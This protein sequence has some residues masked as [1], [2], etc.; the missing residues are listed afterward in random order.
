MKISANLDESLSSLQPALEFRKQRS[1]P[2]EENTVGTVTDAQPYDRSCG[3]E[4]CVVK[5]A[6]RIGD[7]RADVFRLEIGEVSEYLLLCR[8][9]G[10]HVQNVLD[11][12]PHPADAWPPAALIRI[13]GDALKLVHK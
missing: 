9:S 8:S 1:E 11:A 5:I 4:D 6:R 10:Q 12:N 7:A 2:G 3:G 13:K